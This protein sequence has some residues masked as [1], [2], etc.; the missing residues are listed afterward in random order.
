M[1]LDLFDDVLKVPHGRFEERVPFHIK[2]NWREVTQKPILHL[3]TAG[4]G[5]ERRKQQ[6]LAQMARAA[7]ETDL[8]K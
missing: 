6:T 5:F 7:Q 2:G 1:R 4:I 3:K 8:T